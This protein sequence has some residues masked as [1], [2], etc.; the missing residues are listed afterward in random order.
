MMLW[1]DKHRPAGADGLA[2][3]KDAVSAVRKFLHGWKR[4]DGLIIHG[5]PGTGKTLLVTLLAKERGDF[6]LHVDASDT[7]SAKNVTGILG[8]A[9]RQRTLFHKGRI[10]LIDEVDSLSGVADRGA[11]GSILKVIESSSS[12]VIICANDV[13]DPRLKELRKACAKV[14]MD[15]VERKELESYLSAIAVAEGVRVEKG[16]LSSL[17]RWADGDVRSAVLDLQMLSVGGKPVSEERFTSIGFRERGKVLQDVLS[18]IIRSK[19]IKANRAAIRNSDADPDDLFLWLESNIFAASS[20]PA[21]IAG[22]YDA[23]SVADVFRG[24]VARQQN[25]RFKAYMSDIMA[26][27]S[28]LSAQDLQKPETYRF[29]DRIALLAASRFR[30]AAIAPLVDRIGTELHCSE[31]EALL[32]YV[33]FLRLMARGGPRAAEALGLSP[34]EA[35]ALRGAERE[36]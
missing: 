15:K 32:A 2:G 31:R 18:C 35:G 28:S 17:A 33:P 3:Q 9:G 23:L 1:T 34:E 4:G 11:A 16:V 26:G 21:F 29:P 14:R 12:P 36:Y 6:L 8:E 25:W 27:V 30:R 22:A 7:L 10:I 20:D 19:S 13:S 24:R 5:P